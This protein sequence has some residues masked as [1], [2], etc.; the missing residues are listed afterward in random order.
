[1]DININRCA[2]QY[3]HND[4]DTQVGNKNSLQVQNK[5]DNDIDKRKVNIFPSHIEIQNHILCL[6]HYNDFMKN[7]SFKFNCCF[8]CNEKTFK[9]KLN[10]M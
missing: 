7:A 8:V 3:W 10:N 5:Q 1:M 6:K 4:I 2:K 9:A